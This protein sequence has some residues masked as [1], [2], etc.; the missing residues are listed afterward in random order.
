MQHELSLAFVELQEVVTRLAARDRG[1]AVLEA[2]GGVLGA[3]RAG[4]GHRRDARRRVAVALVIGRVRLGDETP[5]RDRLDL[6][7][8][9][10]GARLAHELVG[11]HDRRRLQRLREFD[12][13]GRRR[14][15]IGDRAR[16]DDE[17]RRVAVQAADGKRQVALLA[18][19]RDAGR[20]PAAHDVDD[21][22]RH[23]GRDGQPDAFRH[24]RKT[25]SRR[26]GQRRHAAERRADDH[27]DRGEF[28]L[29]LQ[30]RAADTGQRRRHP[31]EQLG[32]GRDRIGGDEADAAAQRARTGRFVA[33]EQPACAVPG[34]ARGGVRRCGGQ[35]RH[36]R[37][38]GRHGDARLQRLQVRVERA[39]AALPAR[40]HRRFERLRRQPAE[41]AGDAERDHVDPAAGN[42]LDH[43]LQRQRRLARPRGEE[44]LGDFAALGVADKQAA[45][46]QRDLV[47]EAVDVLPVDREQQVEAVVERAERRAPDAQQR[48]RLAA[49]DLRPARAHHQAVQA[50]ARRRVEQQ[51]ARRH[52][53]AAAAARERDRQARA[54]ARCRVARRRFGFRQDFHSLAPGSI[55]MPS[56]R[57]GRALVSDPDQRVRKQSSSQCPKSVLQYQFTGT[58]PRPDR[59]VSAARGSQPPHTT[60]GFDEHRRT[61][62]ADDRA[63]GPDG[64][65]R[66]RGR[67]AGRRSRGRDRRLRR[68]PHRPRLLLRRRAHQRAAAAR[69]RPRDQRPCRR[70]GRGRARLA[71]QVCDRAGGAALR[72]VRPVPARLFDHL[73]HAEDAGQRHPGRL[74]LAHRRPRPRV[75]RGRPR[76]PGARRPHDRRGLDRRRR[77]D[78]ALPGGAPRRRRAGQPR[79]RDRRRRRRR[80]LRAGGG[81]VRREGRRDRCRR[82]QARSDCRPRR[83]AHARQPWLGRE[84]AQ[85]RDQRVREAAGPAQHRVVHL[86]MLGHGARPA[87]R[88]E[89]A[90]ARRDLVGR[91]LHDGQGRSAA[92]QPDGLRRPR[93]RQLGLPARALPRGARPRA[94]RQGA[95]RALHRN[96]SAARH[97]RGVRRRAQPRDQ[98]PRH[99]DSNLSLEN[100]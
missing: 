16:R 88:M 27:V 32:R 5:G 33:A 19:G 26:R 89:P 6:G 100:P 77:A 55:L 50:G 47:G 14:E 97:Q 94:R 66:V 72:R 85:G 22:D 86:R 23:L 82:R 35:P 79:D 21:D 3:R 64:A 42:G 59:P 92:V 17:A 40:A 51:R 43:L 90:R 54:F 68:L 71:R 11:E 36:L 76:A 61:P 83:V 1:F 56:K 73:P 60:E 34:A 41:R 4:N 99:P 63:P 48:G 2:V 80:L 81:R 46:V 20:R 65:R 10:D 93:H 98:A 9:D 28:V 58:A 45:G 13:P 24:Q 37:Q 78:D 84:G 52:H 18:L 44:D 87:H 12:R 29:R 8:V 96:P 39:V 67:A 69:A 31:F 25:R 38:I 70:R 53:A 62:L 95:D 57:S 75:V 15:A 74:R 30:Q 91:R 7:R 49:A